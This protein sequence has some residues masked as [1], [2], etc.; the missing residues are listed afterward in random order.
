M[1]REALHSG[2]STHA[3]LTGGPE[4]SSRCVE[5]NQGT[6]SL[7]GGFLWGPTLSVIPE[8][9]FWVLFKVSLVT[10]CFQLLFLI[11]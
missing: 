3:V 4:P 5:A 7:V 10:F 6:G 11:V 8:S 1:I 2:H 9:F